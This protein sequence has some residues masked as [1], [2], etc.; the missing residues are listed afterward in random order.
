M[1]DGR[2]CSWE[3]RC[4]AHLRIVH[5]RHRSNLC[6]PRRDGRADNSRPINGRSDNCSTYDCDAHDRCSHNSDAISRCIGDPGRGAHHGRSEYYLS[7][8]VG[9]ND[10]H[11]DDR[12]PNN[13]RSNNV[14]SNNRRPNHG[15][16]HH[17]QPHHGSANDSRTDDRRPNDCRPNNNSVDDGGPNVHIWYDDRICH[18]PLASHVP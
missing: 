6:I 8:N 11:T 15:R 3:R 7:N 5:P 9:A 14:R 18:F 2:L 16:P 13:T 12:D 10:R 1:H 4:C 17:V